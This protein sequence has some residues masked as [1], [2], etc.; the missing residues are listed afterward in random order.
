MT[1]INKSEITYYIENIIKSF[2]LKGQNCSKSR[3]NIRKTKI[4]YLAVFDCINFFFPNLRGQGYKLMVLYH[5]MYKINCNQAG[6][7]SKIV[8]NKCIQYFDK[9]CYLNIQNHFLEGK[10]VYIIYFQ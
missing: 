1:Y 2:T 9:K 7:I 3:L 5:R 10:N 4:K 8:I 6:R